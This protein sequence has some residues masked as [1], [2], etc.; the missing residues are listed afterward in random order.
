M[1]IFNDKLTNRDVVDSASTA[2][3]VEEG[4]ARILSVGVDDV[5]GRATTPTGE[6]KAVVSVRA[7]QSGRS[8]VV[9]G[10]SGCGS[11]GY[12]EITTLKLD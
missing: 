3:V 6:G 2:S 7:G 4:A 12:K 5:V 8:I 1:Y 10:S 9:G 11:W